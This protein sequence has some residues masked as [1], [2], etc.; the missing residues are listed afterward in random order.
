MRDDIIEILCDINPLWDPD[1]EDMSIAEFLE[2]KQ[3]MELIV[4]LEDKFD[5][6]IPYDERNE[7]NFENI[8]TIIELL[9][10]L[11]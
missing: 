2:S 4:A 11:Q 9:E 3:L 8:D 7:D 1:D 10:K 6:D 5:V